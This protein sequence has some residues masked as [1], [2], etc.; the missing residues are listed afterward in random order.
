MNGTDAREKEGFKANFSSEDFW[1]TQK[2]KCLY[3]ISLAKPTNEA[4]IKSF[5]SKIGKIT[6]VEIPGNGKVK[7]EQTQ[8]GLKVSFPPGFIPQEGYMIKVQLK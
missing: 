5:N 7:F 8:D 2:G 4:L 3:A 1:F 6:D